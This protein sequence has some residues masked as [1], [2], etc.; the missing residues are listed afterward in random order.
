MMLVAKHVQK[1]VKNVRK[2][3][4]CKQFTQCSKGIASNMMINVI[5]LTDVRYSL[6]LQKRENFVL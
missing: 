4:K 3:A 2:P 5:A 6:P 1:P